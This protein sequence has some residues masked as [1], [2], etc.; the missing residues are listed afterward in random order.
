MRFRG[1]CKQAARDPASHH[2]LTPFWRQPARVRLW[3]HNKKTLRAGGSPVTFRRLKIE[4]PR[5]ETSRLS[6]LQS[7]WADPPR[8]LSQLHVAIFSGEQAEA[9]R[10]RS[11]QK[12]RSRRLPVETIRCFRRANSES[13]SHPR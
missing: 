7:V 13:I 4:N 8:E 5:K 3:A 12:G 11:I 2:R 6:V 10:C 1:Q 9:L